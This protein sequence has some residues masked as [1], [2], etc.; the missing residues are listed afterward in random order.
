MIFKLDENIEISKARRIVDI[1]NLVIHGY[2]K[3]DDVIVWGVISKDLP[4]L[5]EQVEQLTLKLSEER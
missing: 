3:V 5:K 2:D 4:I 1:R